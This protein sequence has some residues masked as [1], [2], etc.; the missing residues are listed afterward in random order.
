MW[1]VIVVL[2]AF[3]TRPFGRM[4]VP[5]KLSKETCNISTASCWELKSNGTLQISD[6]LHLRAHKK[7][8]GSISLF[9]VDIFKVLVFEMGNTMEDSYGNLL[10]RIGTVLNT[11]KIE[12][13]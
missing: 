4:D 7:F 10:Q 9:W 2:N 6:I 5:L 12:L 8:H 13:T 11:C 1:Q 3:E